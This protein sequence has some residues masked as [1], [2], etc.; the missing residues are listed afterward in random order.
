MTT[1][2][3]EPTDN[4]ESAPSGSLGDGHF[5]RI[6][7]EKWRQMMHLP[8]VVAAV[9]QRAKDIRDEANSLV[10]MD[11]RAVARLNP[12]NELAYDYFI[13]N[14]EENS[15]VRARVHP[16]YTNSLGFI[17]DAQN[18]TLLKSME[19]HPSDPIPEGGGVG[20]R[21][22]NQIQEGNPSKAGTRITGLGFDEV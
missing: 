16:S 3:P 6:D 8:P 4:D 17:D 9:E 2:G 15:R 22:W 18:S 11:P 19:A 13:D 5:I 7:E 12:N 1:F 10:A 20:E 14:D 21:A